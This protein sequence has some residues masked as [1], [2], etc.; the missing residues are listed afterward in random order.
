MITEFGIKLDKPIEKIRTWFNNRRA[1][2]RKQG[3]DVQRLPNTPRNT[4]SN[5]PNT[6]ANISS[7]QPPHTATTPALLYAQ[8]QHQQHRILQQQAQAQVN[9]IQ[10]AAKLEI[11][12]S[13]ASP[14]PTT[15]S[16][17]TPPPTISSQPSQP[18]SSVGLTA[19]MLPL[20]LPSLTQSNE[21]DADGNDNMHTHLQLTIKQQQQRSVLSRQ[22]LSAVKQPMPPIALVPETPRKTPQKSL[23][24]ESMPPVPPVAGASPLGNITRRMSNVTPISMPALGAS[25]T[26]PVLNRTTPVSARS[27]GGRSRLT[28]VR[29]RSAR[30]RL[31]DS[32]LKGEGY[33]EDVGLE[34]KFLFGKKRLVYEWYCGENYAESAKN[35]GGPYAKMETNFDS[36]FSMRFVRTRDGSIIE[37]TLSDTPA[38][39][40]Q[41]EN[42]MHKYK[43]RSQQRQYLKAAA[44]QFSVDVTAKDHCIHLRSDEAARVKKTILDS[45]PELA[46][47]VHESTPSHINASPSPTPGPGAFD[48]AG[49]SNSNND[50]LTDS[51]SNNVTTRTDGLIAPSQRKLDF[52]VPGNNANLTGRRPESLD[53]TS[54]MLGTPR[55]QKSPSEPS[56]YKSDV[57][58]PLASPTALV[59]GSSSDRPGNAPMN[60]VAHVWETPT[61][62]N[63]KISRKRSADQA[64]GQAAMNAPT[65][66]GPS[67]A[68]YLIPTPGPWHSPGTPL[69]SEMRTLSNSNINN[70]V[71]LWP[72][73][74]G[75]NMSE[76]VATPLVRRALDFEQGGKNGNNLPGEN[77]LLGR[78]RSLELSSE[79]NNT[80]GNMNK[81]GA[82]A[83]RKKSQSS[84]GSACI[85]PQQPPPMPL[86][87]V[88]P[89]IPPL[90]PGQELTP[91]ASKDDDNDEGMTIEEPKDDSN[92]DINDKI[93][94]NSNNENGAELVVDMVVGNDKTR[95][96]I[97]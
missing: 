27:S 31:G 41:S 63:M 16:P 15:N 88:L 2:D 65:T 60:S 71:S 74:G 52:S 66:T 14:S 82:V 48:I 57:A 47:L 3:I 35:T 91:T 40:L 93:D 97:V 84:S 4:T 39:Y 90:L 50:R 33:K 55:P 28:P 67:N 77:E 87:P 32:E 1:L 44:D 72:A 73:I 76:H 80:D 46:I 25:L 6:N 89:P 79:D 59:K 21:D 45:V 92:E 83:K 8:Q 70:N 30:L 22:N 56:S 68:A 19:S 69:T 13:P 12:A 62:S 11:T 51:E 7:S 54:Q 29:L 20:P 43:A 95:D 61:R 81:M 17:P 5:T 85:V 49:F 10:A 23:Q 42:N 86:P 96:E 38:L 36:L 34:V 24:S 18:S 78:K 9:A 26:T 94:E 58:R 75:G 53:I 37:M 64:L